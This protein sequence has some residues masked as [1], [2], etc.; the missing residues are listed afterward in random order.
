MATRHAP[1]RRLHP[2]ALLPRAGGDAA[3]GRCRGLA[4][5]A[6]DPRPHRR[7]HRRRNAVREVAAL[8]GS[9]TLRHGVYLRCGEH[10]SARA[11]RARVTMA[12]VVLVAGTVLLVNGRTFQVL[13]AYVVLSVMVGALG[14]TAALASPATFALFAVATV[15]KV[16]LA[17]LGIVLFVRANPAAADLRPSISAPGRLL[18]VIAFAVLAK[19]VT[20]LPAVAT[21][22]MADLV[23]FVVLCGV[24]MLIIHRNLLAHMVG[25]LVLSIGIGLAASMLAPGLPEPIELGTAFDALVATV[26]GLALVRAI[27]VHDPLLDVESLRRLRG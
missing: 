26:I 13:I 19:I 5:S 14:I 4:P 7:G 6:V 21:V 22:P 3:S 11:G 9:A 1:V 8:R 2:S 23:A 25:L 15:L 10:R 16:V 20:R 18:I 17:P 27:V 12:V 24:G